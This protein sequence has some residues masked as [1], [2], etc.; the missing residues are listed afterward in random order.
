MSNTYNS[1]HLRLSSTI[2]DF[3]TKKSF[4]AGISKQQIIRTMIEKCLSD[5]YG[6]NVV[7][8]GNKIKEQISNKHE[9][10]TNNQKLD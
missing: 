10:L 3:I 7:L 1:I 5:E 9:I 2:H 8:N 6:E 4:E